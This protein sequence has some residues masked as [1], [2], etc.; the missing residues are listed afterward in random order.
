M[1]SVCMAFPRTL[2]Q[3]KVPSSPPESGRPS[4]KLWGPRSVS[5]PET[6][7]S[8]MARQSGQTK[9]WS[10]LFAVWLPVSRPSGLHTCLGNNMPTTHW[11]APPL[12][13]PHSW[14]R[15]GSNPPCSPAR[16]RRQQFHRCKHSSN[17]RAESGGKPEPPWT[18]QLLGTDG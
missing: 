12:D 4:V 9:V 5:H 17:E 3:T 18:E 6:T 11:S 16:R 14:S 15:T 8:P 1:F 10:P 2:F 7:H 13:C